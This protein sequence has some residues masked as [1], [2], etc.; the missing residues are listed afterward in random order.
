LKINCKPC[1]DGKHNECVDENCLC[2][3]GHSKQELINEFTETMKKVLP[4]SPAEL[5][6]IIKK[7][8]KL[9]KK[10]NAEKL[11]TEKENKDE[12]QDSKKLFDFAKKQLEKTIIS[13]YDTSKVYGLI[14]I[15][16]HFET[17]QLDSQRATHWLSHQYHQVDANVI[18]NPDFFKNTLHAL[19]AEAQMNG[20]INESVHTRIGQ[21][22][23]EIYYD[24]GSKD[25][26]AVKITKNRISIV[27]IDEKTPMFVRPSSL[28]EQ[29]KPKYDNKN[30]IE[31]LADLLLILDE[32]KIIFKPNLIGMFLESVAVPMQVATGSAD[33]SKSTF[34]ALL[35]RVVDPSGKI[36]ENNLIGFPKKKED[37]I[38][39]ES[40]RYM[41]AF[42]NVSEID[43]EMSDELCRSITGGSNSARKYYTNSDESISSY[44][45][46]I[47]L[48]GIIPRLDYPDLQ[49]RIITY[50][51]KPLDH[52]N[53]LTDLELEDKFNKLLP[54]VLGCIFKTLQKSLKAYPTVKKQVKPIQRLAD[55][56]IW[57]E[58]IAQCLG[59]EP[60]AFL[61]AYDRKIKEDAINTKE[62]HVI[63]DLIASIM[64]GR[65][66]YENQAKILFNEIKARAEDEGIDVKSRYVYFPKLPNQLT[67]ELTKVNPI[68]KQ[69]GFIVNTFH[70]K[71]NDGKFNKNA[72]I[73]RISKKEE[74]KTLE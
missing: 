20:T 7:H 18:H 15:N 39:I 24:L 27:K 4:Q 45:N 70:Y 47:I 61:K 56:E 22:K 28:Y 9:E 25:Y 31:D 65:Q 19:V 29:V 17:I 63:V 51:R 72:M 42:D 10:R 13:T 67:R 33:S 48:N 60:R 69:M 21:N 53:R 55:F 62:S 3:E 34:T 68:L 59:Y 49:T 14:S 71:K 5:K 54:Q 11:K 46:K 35:K 50:Q 37:L 64:E 40:H 1:M 43:Q 12:R 57:G 30:A 66:V 52:T 26:K 41:M 36:K 8:K 58:T 32:D 38:A 44:K 74:Q 16:N 2:R 73:V 23:N 6:K